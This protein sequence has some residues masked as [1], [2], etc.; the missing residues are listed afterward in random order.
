MNYSDPTGSFFGGHFTY[1]DSLT[2]ATIQT[3]SG[4]PVCETSAMAQP[5]SHSSVYAA[6][7]MGQPV[8][9]M[10]T[11]FEESDEAL[12]NTL[13][14]IHYTE[15]SEQPDHPIYS[16]DQSKGLEQVVFYSGA[17]PVVDNSRACVPSNVPNSLQTAS[18]STLANMP[19]P[20][21][22]ER[23]A[24]SHLFS[25]QQNVG[26]DLPDGNVSADLAQLTMIP[27]ETSEVRT[28][29]TEE[30]EVQ[31]ATA[32]L[33]HANQDYKLTEFALPIQMDM[34]GVGEFHV[35]ESNYMASME[36]LKE[37]NSLVLLDPNEA[38]PFETNLALANEIYYHNISTHLSEVEALDI[39][40]PLKNEVGFYDL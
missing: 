12:P 27:N 22:F 30:E 15:I 21:K 16:N 36:R 33:L 24:L 26:L 31:N 23:G 29:G 37:S 9:Q 35:T 40:H 39:A 4:L 28:D 17:A 19:F 3:H 13:P 14:T 5:H 38:Q 20:S 34:N 11:M 25:I 10:F 2:T 7:F 8:V 32:A 6:E 1:P 18:F